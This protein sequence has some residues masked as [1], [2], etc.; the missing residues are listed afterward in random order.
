MNVKER[1]VQEIYDEARVYVIKVLVQ[2]AMIT[3][4]ITSRKKQYHRVTSPSIN[5]LSKRIVLW[6]FLFFN[7]I[8]VR[9]VSYK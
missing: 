4:R 8:L 9:G 3:E 7:L 5:D 2:G 1:L 6:V